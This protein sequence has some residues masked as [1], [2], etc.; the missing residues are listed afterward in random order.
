MNRSQF[1]NR[2]NYY[3]VAKV[4]H[5]SAH[6]RCHIRTLENVAAHAIVELIWDDLGK[7]EFLF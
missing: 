4:Y 5:A 1:V 2:E 3:G 7:G 6:N